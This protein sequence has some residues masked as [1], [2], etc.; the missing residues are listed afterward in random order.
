MLVNLALSFIKR[1]SI[2]NMLSENA[3]FFIFYMSPPGHES[4]IFPRVHEVAGQNDLKLVRGLE[5][6]TFKLEH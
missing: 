3:L 1:S 4:S 5:K 2:I 6:S